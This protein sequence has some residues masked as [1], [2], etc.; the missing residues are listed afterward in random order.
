MLLAPALVATLLAACGSQQN[1]TDTMTTATPGTTPTDSTNMTAIM[2]D[3]ITTHNGGT[4]TGAGDRLRNDVHAA[5]QDIKE[6]Y[7]DAR[8][9]TAD[10]AHKVGHDIKQGYK[11]TRSDIKA[12]VEAAKEHKEQREHR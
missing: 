9:A 11:N 8:D 5:G 6:G 4:D 10:A 12:G 7:K 1:S 3:T 2:P